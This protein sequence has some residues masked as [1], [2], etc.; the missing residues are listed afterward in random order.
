M[1]VARPRANAIA[2]KSI[3]AARDIRKGEPFTEENLT[4]KRPV[5]GIS[6]M[7]WDEIVGKHAQKKYIEDELI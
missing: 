4:A 7:R 3:V 5:T 2:R 6:P 1:H